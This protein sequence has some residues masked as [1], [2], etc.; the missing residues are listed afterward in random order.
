MYIPVMKREL[1]IVIISDVHLGTYGSHAEALLNYLKS[2]KPGTLIING[3]FIDIW[4]FRKS[5]FP[6]TH[7]QVI[8]RIL[9][10]AN[11]GTTVYYLTGNHDEA[12]RRYSNFSTGN[13]HLRDSLELQCKGESYLIFH[14]DVFDHSLKYSPFIAKLGGKSYDYLI[15]LN[16][17]IND[18]RQWMGWSRYS[19]AQRIKNKVKEAVKFINDFEESAIKYAA[20]RGHDFVVC[21]HIHQAQMRKMQLGDR[22]ITYLNSGDWVESLSALEYHRGEWSLYEYQEQ[23]F[24]KNTKKHQDKPVFDADDFEVGIEKMRAM[25]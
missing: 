5:Y 14:G 25:M 8:N 12:L 16:R 3:D 24:E 2:I 9:Q 17:L 19:F 11:K 23:D 10:L 7:M 20:E 1:D 15:L 21:G 6:K 13:I 4:Q 18:F 22:S